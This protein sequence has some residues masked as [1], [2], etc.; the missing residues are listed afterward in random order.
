LTL[1]EE[2]MANFDVKLKQMMTNMALEASS[3][4][5]SMA[6]PASISNRQIHNNTNSCTSPSQYIDIFEG[7][8]EP[9]KLLTSPMH[10]TDDS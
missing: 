1:L 4:S 9:V 10:H 5:L 7:S 2:A 6:Y 8:T 3:K